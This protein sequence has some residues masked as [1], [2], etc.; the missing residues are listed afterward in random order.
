MLQ[1]IINSLNSMSS[2]LR[3]IKSFLCRHNRLIANTTGAVFAGYI[4]NHVYNME[5]KD[6]FERIM[7]TIGTSFIGFGIGEH[8]RVALM[9]IASAAA[10]RLLHR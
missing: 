5:H 2:Q 6:E 3:P 7:L 10:L 1:L 4:A 9:I 8:Y